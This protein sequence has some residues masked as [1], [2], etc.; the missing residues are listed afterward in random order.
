MVN[1][2]VDAYLSHVTATVDNLTNIYDEAAP[3]YAT[4]N[5]TGMAMDQANFQFKMKLDPFSYHPTFHM[6]LRLIG[7]DLTKINQ[8]ARAY[9]M[10]DFE[11][12]FF[13]LVIEA[14]STEGQV[15]GYV[16]P[17]FRDMQIFG[18]K[19]IQ[20]DNV[21]EAFWEALLGTATGVL[22]NHPRNQFGTRIPFTGDISGPQADL[23]AGV[24]AIIRNAFIRAYL[25]RLEGIAD[26]NS[27]IQ[28]E[29][30]SILEPD[31]VGEIE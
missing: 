9:G 15:I 7:L 5:A 13:D 31:S 6:G 22:T 10:F 1:P 24:G 26:E 29:K 18:P 16:K 3:M 28:F 2:P 17:L 27:P 19:D 4:V 12:G 23:L 21:V 30:G 25:P 11:K 8:L 14:N 20:E